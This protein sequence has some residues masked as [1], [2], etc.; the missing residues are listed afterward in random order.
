MLLY[1]SPHP[2]LHS[3]LLDIYR[4][5]AINP[6][7]SKYFLKITQHSWKSSDFF[8]VKKIS[9]GGNWESSYSMKWLLF[10]RTASILDLNLLQA[11]TMVSLSRD[12]TSA[13]IFKNRS[14]IL[15][16]GFA[17]TYNSETPHTK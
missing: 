12:P 2:F 10:V 15:L 8:K 9:R 14:S 6:E 3:R 17:L 11:F 4:V 13:F 5:A 7:F 1:D 16:W